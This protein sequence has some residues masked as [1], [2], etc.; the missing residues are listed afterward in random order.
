MVVKDSLSDHVLYLGSSTTSGFCGFD[1]KHRRL[2]CSIGSLPNGGSA[3]VTIQTI[4]RRNGD[5]DN[6]GTVTSH[7]KDPH[8]GDNSSQIRVH[9]H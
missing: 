8:T 9:V 4:I 2:T 7:T 5:F 3:T 1:F 6:K